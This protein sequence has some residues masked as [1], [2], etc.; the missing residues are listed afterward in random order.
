[1]HCLRKDSQKWEKESNI[2]SEGSSVYNEHIVVNT[3]I[4]RGL[5]EMVHNLK[6]LAISFHSANGRKYPYK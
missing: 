5:V 6:T 3:P 1:M 4:S 2:K